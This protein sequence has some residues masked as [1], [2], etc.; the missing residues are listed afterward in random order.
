MTGPLNAPCAQLK[1]Y[2]P[3]QL[4]VLGDIMDIYSQEI[5]KEDGE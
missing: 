3:E 5:M 1:K 4:A 2:S